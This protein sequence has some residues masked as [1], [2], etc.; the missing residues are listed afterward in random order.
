MFRKK[1]CECGDVLNL[2]SVIVIETWLCK[3]QSL[4][5]FPIDRVFSFTST[6]EILTMR[7][8]REIY[9]F[10]VESLICSLTKDLTQTG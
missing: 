5:R 4:F 9:L 10:S 1:A 6:R 3:S 8:V 2:I 7:F